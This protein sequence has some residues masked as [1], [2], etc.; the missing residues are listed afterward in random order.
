MTIRGP[1]PAA[2]HDADLHRF[3][4]CHRCLLDVQS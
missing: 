1:R 2:W 4:L 3:R